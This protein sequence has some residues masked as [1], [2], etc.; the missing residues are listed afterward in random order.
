MR[1][2]LE[3]KF[4]NA[5]HNQ[6]CVCLFGQQFH[7]RDLSSSRYI[8]THKKSHVHKIM[9]CLK[10]QK[11]L[12]KLWHVH[13]VEYDIV[14]KKNEREFPGNPVV[15]TLSLLAPR[16]IPCLGTKI[17]QTMWH[18]QNYKKKKKK[19]QESSLY[20]E[21]CPRC[22]IKIKKNKQG[23]EKQCSVYYHIKGGG[24]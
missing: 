16:F 3:R 11:T 22:I 4:G 13:T 6:K 14:Q 19:E 10:Q 12:N 24:R 21:R 7:S 15:R 2:T 9:C 1:T 5:Y 18:H 8:H 23:G 20:K 17:L